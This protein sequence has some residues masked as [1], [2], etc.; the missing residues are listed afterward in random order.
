MKNKIETNKIIEVVKKEFANN[1]DLNC[2]SLYSWG[3]VARG[4]MTSYSDLDFII[5]CDKKIELKKIK[6]FKSKIAMILPKNYVDILEVYSKKELIK[7]SLIDGTDMEAILLM[8]HVIGKKQNFKPV[9][10]E[11]LLKEIIHNYCNLEFV[12]KNIVETNLKFG[13]YRIKYYNIAILI[14]LFFGCKKTSTLDSLK[15]LKLTGKIKLSNNYKKEYIELLYYKSMV[16][17][18]NK[19]YNAEVDLEK[20]IKKYGVEDYKVMI[21]N[22]KRNKKNSFYLFLQLKKVVYSIIV[23]NVLEREKVFFKKA[24]S[25]KLTKKDIE[26]SINYN[27]ELTMLYLSYFVKDQKTLEK[28]RISNKKNWYL[29]YGIVN[30]KHSN[31]ITI[32]KSFYSG[33]SEY[34][35]SKLYTSFAWRNI[36]LY[37][38]KNPN[39][40]FRIKNYILNYSNARN[41]DI[42]SAKKMNVDKKK[43]VLYFDNIIENN[44]KILKNQLNIYNTEIYLGKII[45][46]FFY[47]KYEI[48]FIKENN[49]LNE[50]LLKKLKKYEVEIIDSDYKFDFID[51]IQEIYGLQEIVLLSNLLK[52]RK[53]FEKKRIKT[54]FLMKFEPL[55]LNEEKQEYFFAHCI[56]KTNELKMFF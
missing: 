40:D 30:N 5:I 18:A 26:I 42:L 36:Y 37:A 19:D 47:K 14:A 55:I 50:K 12:Y 32:L 53:V 35:L 41:M 15:F 13:Q 27:D 10:K 9:K 49:N 3:S 8:K 46:Y 11:K 16:Q 6:T 17:E 25:N 1:F 28:I 4:E 7:L 54:I 38:T 21:Q 43:I 24:F 52:Y 56:Q 45:K 29:L 48:T 20:F 34:K 23:N 2:Y 51:K 39:S 44:S 31:V 33:Y 22:L